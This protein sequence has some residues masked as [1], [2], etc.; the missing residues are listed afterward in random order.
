MFVDARHMETDQVLRA[1]LCIIGAG[2]AGITIADAL[3]DTGVDV[4]L[5]EA[6]GLEY[7]EQD[8]SMY[9]GRNV[10]VSYLPLDT[11]RLRYF[12]GTT[13][14]WGGRCQPLAD[15]DFQRRPWIRHS[16]W[17][18]TRQSLEPFYLRAQSV[19][20]LGPMAYEEENWKQLGFTGLGVDRRKL[21]QRRWQLSPPVRFGQAFRDDLKAAKNIK[22]VLNANVDTIQATPA[23]NAISGVRFRTLEGRRGRAVARAYILACGGIENARLLLVSNTVEKDGLGNQHDQ[24]GRFFMAHANVTVGNILSTNSKAFVAALGHQKFS[25][26]GLHPS[27]T[28]QEAEEILNAGA[29]IEFRETPESAILAARAIKIDLEAGRVPDDLA[30]AL[31]RVIRDIDDV[32]VALWQHYVEDRSTYNSAS[33]LSLGLDLEQAPSPDSRVSLSRDVDALGMKR[34][35]L[36]LRVTDLHKRTALAVTMAIAA[37]IGRLGLGRVQLAD[38]LRKPGDKRPPKTNWKNHHMGTT[39]MSDDPR[40]GVVDRDCKVHTIENLYLAGSSVFST[41]GYA[42][43]TLTIVALALRLADHLKTRFKSRI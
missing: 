41:G 19:L 31:W 4:C 37:E 30:E 9:H 11:C 33:L 10:G 32:A 24:V 3:K 34:V 22:V 20:K 14:H 42:N 23:G 29:M 36:D 16:G 12:G 27:E 25:F 8:Q 26:G 40:A 21:V 39:R 43:P 18:I 5:L 6:G 38:W 35:T 28:L 2:A 15:I 13:N 1:D 17:P 7:S